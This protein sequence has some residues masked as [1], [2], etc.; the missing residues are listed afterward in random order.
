MARRVARRYSRGPTVD[1]DLQQVACLGL[2]LAAGRYDPEVGPFQPYAMATVS[3]EVKRY[4]RDTGW[5][6]RVS[7]SLQEQSQRVEQVEVELAAALNRSPTP[8]E[9]GSHLDLSV[10][11]VL[12]AARARDAR[13][14]DSL[15]GHEIEAVDDD[16]AFAVSV[17]TAIEQLDAEDRLLLGLR[18][19]E[20][21]T[22]REVAAQ[23][24]VSQSQ[25]HRSRRGGA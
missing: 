25:V 14:A 23:L 16:L 2:V 22:Q 7:R 11:D 8:A 17:R 15:D 3:G 18:F 6:V 1:P 9:I 24:G 13:F 5:S 10:E 12:A 20:Q 21:L 4:L 19:E